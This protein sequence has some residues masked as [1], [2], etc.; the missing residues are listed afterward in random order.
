MNA[1]LLSDTPPHRAAPLALW[2]VAEAFMHML[3]NLFGAPEHIAEKH[4][5]TAGPYAL[6]ASWLRA[7]EALMR[8]LLII[9]ASAHPR[10]NT[11]P[12]LWPKRA[13]VRRLHGFDAEY[14]EAW[15]VSFR[16]FSSPARGGSGARRS[17]VTK[18]A[19]AAPSDR[20]AITS[21]ARGGG[22]RFYSVWPL[23]ERYEALLR[24]FND[25]SPFARRLAKRLHAT[26]HRLKAML[27]APP[28]APGKVGFEEFA[29]L[30][31]AAAST[32][33]VFNSS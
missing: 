33:A 32:D 1:S 6:I 7:G 23:A 25:P 8:R 4:T 17:R 28:D 30:S 5:L 27:R 19:A 26:G 29:T 20:F 12:I 31:D 9:E 15:R 3:Y 18:G 13:R 21:P 11:R 22:K 14:S 24:V 16:C 2:R 10:P